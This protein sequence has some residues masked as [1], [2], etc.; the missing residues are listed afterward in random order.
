MPG[1]HGHRT[2]FYT[3]KLLACT[4]NS[5]FLMTLIHTSALANPLGANIAA[6][7]A[8]ISQQDKILTIKQTSNRA[9]IDWNS[10]DIQH[11]EITRFQQPDSSA[12]TLNRIHSQHPS[13][14]LGSMTANG[15]VVLINPNGIVF[16]NS[17]HVDVN[18]LI[19]MTSDTGND[20]FMKGGAL[21][22]TKPGNPN[23][24]IRNDGT[25]TAKDAGLVGLVAPNV[26]N[27]GT[28]NARLGKVHLASGDVATIDMYGDQLIQLAISDNVHQQLVA[29]NGTVNADGGIITLTAAAG[30]Q[31]VNSM[32]NVSGELNAATIADQQGKITVQAGSSPAKSTVLVKGK[33]NSSGTQDGT[34]GGNIDI[35]GDNVALLAGSS[36]TASGNAGGG[37]VRVGGDYLGQGEMAHAA[38]TVVQKG[39][40]IKANATHRGDGGKVILWSDR[41]TNFQ[42]SIDASGAGSGK[43]G[44]VE[45]S[46]KHNLQ[47]TGSVYT[48]GGSWLLDPGSITIQSSGP[49]DTIDNDGPL[50]EAPSGTDAI[51]TSS[52]IENA[53]YGT[54]GT[55]G[56][57]V[58]I[59]TGSTGA[60]AGDIY[61]GDDIDYLGSATRNFTLEA[62]SNIFMT[63]YNIISANAPLNVTFNS[64]Y[65]GASTGFVRVNSSSVITHGGHFTIGGGAGATSYAV[66]A[67]GWSAAVILNSHINTAG[68]NITIRGQS[69]VGAD[70]TVGVFIVGSTTVQTTTGNITLQGIGGSGSNDMTGV[71]IGGFNAPQITTVSGQINLNG[72]GGI[73][74]GDNADGVYIDAGG[75]VISTGNT[76]TPGAITITG[77]AGSGANGVNGI[78]LSDGHILSAFADIQLN[79]ATI[80]NNSYGVLLENGSEI[81]STGAT[82]GDISILANSSNFTDFR[83]LG[84]PILIG[85]ANSLKDIT[86]HADEVDMSGTTIDTKG[87]V[88]FAPRTAGTSIGI[89][90][91]S[92]SGTLSLT[93]AELGFITNNVARLVIGD[94]NAGDISV[95]A[96][97]LSSKLYD[98]ALYGNDI[99]LDGI[100]L[101]VGDFFTYAQNNIVSDTGSLTIS[102]L[103]SKTLSGLSNLTFKADHDININNDITM[104]TGSADISLQADAE[105]DHAGDI[106]HNAN[107]TSNGGNVD[108]A[109]HNVDLNGD[110]TAGAGTITAQTGANITYSSGTLSADTL[111]LD[112][113]G[114]MTAHIN[115]NHVNIHNH[116]INAVLTG[117]VGGL[118]TQ[119]AADTILGGP[120]NNANYTFENFIIRLAPIIVPPPSTPEPAP[121]PLSIWNDYVQEADGKVL[122]PEYWCGLM[123]LT[124]SCKRTLM[125]EKPKTDIEIEGL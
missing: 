90:A 40:V 109:G 104:T 84:S 30:S 28:I 22:F 119:L 92:G 59:R 83:T 24:T 29:N 99:T 47:A 77:N 93:N 101:G 108:I 113:N 88:T 1:Y 10:F 107:I 94:A 112:A 123:P 73:S 78:H 58:I 6:G 117:L 68:G 49:T 39:A 110:M 33:L 72:T 11:D 17:A 5:I 76:G 106:K 35:T 38:N 96:W 48:R 124:G 46:S 41:Y 98:I 9:V 95:G 27:N 97:N 100:T 45:T 50:F 14:I 15:N 118:A 23:A 62:Y 63:G 69:G 44:F 80:D 3:K 86:I 13:S 34:R 114:T 74:A 36:I 7:D 21:N 31:I 70:D 66:G 19:A 2:L 125:W 121:T 85:G 105:G 18:G 61:F 20:Q 16:G 81:T 54:N 75:K 82:I 111:S 115:A 120:G 55:D 60:G 122:E 87:I 53:L 25:I 79:G 8:S 103:I 37:T 4:T 51:V 43:G 26:L 67:P 32:I 116:S 52:A 64:R 57:D 102:N 91:N 71:R 89:A 56:A 65:T 12:I 42:G